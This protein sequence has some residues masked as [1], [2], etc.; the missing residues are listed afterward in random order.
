MHNKTL[1]IFMRGGVGI[2]DTRAEKRGNLPLLFR[3]I[4]VP[5]R[6]EKRY[7]KEKS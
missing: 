6:V 4:P 3:E 2:I 7:R 5:D 1:D